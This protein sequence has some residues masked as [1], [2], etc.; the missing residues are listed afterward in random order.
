M[1]KLTFELFPRN[2]K[3]H[4]YK[5]LQGHEFR[6]VLMDW[7]AKINPELVEKLHQANKERPYAIKFIINKKLS[8]IDFI[9]TSFDPEINQSIL[10]GIVLKDE[11]N[12]IIKNRSYFIST[13][14]WEN[15]DL[16]CLIELSK[17]VNSFR[18]RFITPVSF[19]TSLG[20][21]PVRFPL[22]SILFG[23]LCNLWNSV[24]ENF[25]KLERDE[26]IKWVNTHVYVSYYDMRTVKRN[27][28][29]PK[30]IVGGI[31]VASYRI[32]NIDTHFYKNITGDIEDNE[33]RVNFI[34][35][36]HVQKCCWI[37]ILCKL[38]EFIN[39]GTNRTAGMGVIRYKPNKFFQEIQE[40]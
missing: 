8:K 28:G 10:D 31:G 23:N 36:D 32:K 18:L 17:P 35:K 34:I 16:N 33:T 40:V 12:V 5:K 21:Y 27:I 26:F 22:P 14:K 29:K 3:I 25:K 9:I 37:D 1:I 4:S 15:H 6:A 38:G 13:I 19:N 24:S 39:V 11:A 30:P 2:G 20:N 7:L